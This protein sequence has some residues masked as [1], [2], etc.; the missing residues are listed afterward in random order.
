MIIQQH[1]IR[2]KRQPKDYALHVLHSHSHSDH[3][4]ADSQFYGVEGVSV[5]PPHQL[6]VL[7]KTLQLSDWPNSVS[8]FKLGG[9]NISVIPT[10][11]HQREA[12]SLYDDQTQWLLTGDTFYPGRLYIRDWLTFKSSIARLVAFT[13]MNPV[14]AILGAH[15]EMSACAKKDY[16]SGSVYHPN[17]ASLVLT[18][19]DLQLL[20][21][22]L[23]IMG[24][25]PQQVR[26]DKFIIFPLI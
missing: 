9:R 7:Q 23:T 16:P 14:S 11:G 12:I 24:Q 3:I 1:L 13:E 17:E 25:Q 5:V 2:I 21:R 19:K 15:I 8:V 6:T 22:Q 26:M 20:H 18:T 10:P 4:A